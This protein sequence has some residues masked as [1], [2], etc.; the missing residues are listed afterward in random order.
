MH[1]STKPPPL[2]Q[3][4]TFPLTTLSF[5]LFFPRFNSYLD[6][7]FSGVFGFN[8]QEN[9]YPAH[10]YPRYGIAIPAMMQIHPLGC[11]EFPVC[12]DVNP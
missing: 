3:L 4:L 2:P 1:S 12:R 5:S 11:N 10:A 6:E 7:M 8:E 9:Y